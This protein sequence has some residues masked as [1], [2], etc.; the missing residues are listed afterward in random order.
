ME[1]TK[2]ELR[3]FLKNFGEIYKIKDENLKASL[4]EL[5][6]IIDTYFLYARPPKYVLLDWEI[7]DALRMKSAIR[8]NSLFGGDKNSHI[9]HCDLYPYFISFKRKKQLDLIL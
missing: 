3:E 8:S 2:G 4:S 5:S 1:I 7:D 9:K 6:G